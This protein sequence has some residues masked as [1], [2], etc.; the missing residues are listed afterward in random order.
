M[1]GALFAGVLAAAVAQSLG[2][3]PAVGEAELS[4][5]AYREV[6]TGEEVLS[7]LGLTFYVAG[8]STAISTVLAV[9][10]ALALRRAS[11]RVSSVVFQLP[12]TIPHLVAA[13]A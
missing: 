9:L 3:M 7:S 8:S 2:Y 6:L 13:V 4:L 11:G 10:A 12:I 1:I 5:D